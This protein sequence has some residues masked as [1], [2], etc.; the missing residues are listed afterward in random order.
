MPG[1]KRVGDTRHRAGKV[2]ARR[3]RH[4]HPRAYDAWSDPGC[5]VL[6]HIELECEARCVVHDREHVGAGI[7]RSPCTRLPMS[8]L[9]CVMTPLNGARRR[10]IDR[11]PDAAS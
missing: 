10:C 6:R 11:G 2:A 4:T 1:W 3:L 8:T 9:R 5:L 7:W